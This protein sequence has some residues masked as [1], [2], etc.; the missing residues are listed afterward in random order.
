[1]EQIE[2]NRVQQREIQKLRGQVQGM[3]T[4]VASQQYQPQSTRGSHVS[5]RYMDTAQFYGGWRR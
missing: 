1:L 4:P 5:A 2:A 3:A